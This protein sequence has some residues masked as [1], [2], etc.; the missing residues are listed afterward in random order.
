VEAAAAYE[1]YLHDGTESR[2]QEALTLFR[3]GLIYARSDSS[4]YD[5]SRSVE[6][7]SRSLELVPDS[8]FNLEAR[9]IL[10]LEREAVQ[11]RVDVVERRQRIENLFAELSE[12]QEQIEK[13]EG[14]AGAREEK[15]DTLS[16]QISNLRRQIES[17][18]RE[19]EGKEEELERLKAIDFDSKE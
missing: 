14:Q 7:L 19:V 17:L 2:D 3:L 9:L 11:L 4:I 12:L 5:P 1:E 18:M 16:T 15:V 8:S 10:G 6:M 13:A